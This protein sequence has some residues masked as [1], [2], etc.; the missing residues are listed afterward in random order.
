M[1]SQVGLNGRSKFV[2]HCHVFGGSSSINDLIMIFDNQIQVG[3]TSCGCSLGQT[4]GS[5]PTE[6]AVL[7]I[8][9]GASVV[10]WAGLCGC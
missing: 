3:A 1:V 9:Q 8:Y 2:P 10:C 4:H 6:R 5:A 7:K